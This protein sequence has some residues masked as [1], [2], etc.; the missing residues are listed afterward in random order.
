MRLFLFDKKSIFSL[1]DD[2]ISIIMSS[3]NGRQ[4]RV[5]PQVRGRESGGR[6]GVR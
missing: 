6:F 5:V 2:K 3:T 1:T 4:V